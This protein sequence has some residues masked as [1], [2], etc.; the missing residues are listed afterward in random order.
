ML[1]GEEPGHPCQTQGHPGPLLRTCFN[2][3]AA[4]DGGPLRELA[5][6]SA[7]VKPQLHFPPTLR[8]ETKPREVRITQRHLLVLI[9]APSPPDWAARLPPDK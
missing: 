2:P 7:S 5:S 6:S 9:S 3:W 1:S 8:T 4:G